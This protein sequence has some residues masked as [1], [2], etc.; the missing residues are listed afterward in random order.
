[1]KNLI[2][3]CIT[4]L[5]CVLLSCI[6][7]P[8]TTFA[9]GEPSDGFYKIKCVGTGEYLTVN[10]E[11]ITLGSTGTIFDIKDTEPSPSIKWFSITSGNRA[12][13]FSNKDSN[14]S[15]ESL[16]PGSLNYGDPNYYLYTCQR[17]T[18]GKTASGYNIRSIAF[19]NNSDNRVLTVENGS[20]CLRRANGSKNQ[21]FI[22]E[23]Q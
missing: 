7:Y 10:N 11:K 21:I 14:A 8:L 13:S 18:F 20:L 23:W 5:L 3:S 16:I 15:L 1:M 22:L 17:F 4:L 9:A 6:S 19:G 2:K 12:L